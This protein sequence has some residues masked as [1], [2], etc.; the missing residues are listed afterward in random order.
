MGKA[1]LGYLGSVLIFFAAVLMFVAKSYVSAAVLLVVSVVG[2][3][4]KY[5]MNRK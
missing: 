5:K 2:M 1:W 3:V 4:L